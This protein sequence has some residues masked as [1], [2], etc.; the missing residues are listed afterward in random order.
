MCD[1]H[2]S[3]QHGSCDLRVGSNNF[4][5]GFFSSPP[6]TNHMTMSTHCHLGTFCF[7]LLINLNTLIITDGGTSSHQIEIFHKSKLPKFYLVLLKGVPGSEC[8]TGP[9]L[10]GCLLRLKKKK[11]MSSFFSPCEACLSTTRALM[12]IEFQLYT[13]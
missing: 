2:P 11:R 4:K 8:Q 3:N 13:T 12:I 6:S 9:W 10:V 7:S 5:K 1:V